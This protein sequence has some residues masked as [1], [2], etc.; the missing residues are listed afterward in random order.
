MVPYLV[1][2]DE[3]IAEGI[4][5]SYIKVLDYTKISIILGGK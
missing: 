4:E 3:K 1:Q 2:N 5:G